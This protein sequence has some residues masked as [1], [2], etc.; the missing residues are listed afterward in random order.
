MNMIVLL[1]PHT[2]EIKMSSYQGVLI[3]GMSS[4][5]G[6]LIRGMSSYQGVLIR[7]TS[8]YQGVLIRGTFSYEGVLIRG[9]SSAALAPHQLWSPDYYSRWNECTCLRR[10]VTWSRLLRKR[11][12]ENPATREDLAVVYPPR[13]GHC[14]IQ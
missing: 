14:S 10:A 12:R 7:G 4:Y 5:Q 13:E 2:K 6:V 11:W 3:R 8:S 9:M 1:G